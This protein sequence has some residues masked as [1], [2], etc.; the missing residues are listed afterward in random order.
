MREGA[1]AVGEILHLAGTV[2]AQTFDP[3]VPHAW[4]D[5][6]VT[7]LEVPLAQRDRSG[8]SPRA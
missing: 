7:E 1:L 6:D 3:D 5:K 8:W 2:V 4:N